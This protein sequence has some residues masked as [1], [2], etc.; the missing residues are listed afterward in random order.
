MAHASL[1]ELN[2]DASNRLVASTTSDLA[3]TAAGVLA[4]A[5][6]VNPVT[7]VNGQKR[8]DW[9]AAGMV[10]NHGKKLA[11]ELFTVGANVNGIT[12]GGNI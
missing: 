7:D 9:L 1:A 11:G 4:K 12:T 5:I 8:A 2:A 3:V 6:S 10:D